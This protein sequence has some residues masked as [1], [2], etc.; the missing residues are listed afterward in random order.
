KDKEDKQSDGRVINLSFLLD[1]TNLG[2][3][4]ADFSILKKAITGRF[5]LCDD[6]IRQFISTMIPQLK[7]RMEKQGYQVHQ[8]TCETVEKV[9][10]AVNT[11]IEETL[12][13]EDDRVLNIVI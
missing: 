1:M 8:I 4:R 6:D 13:M 10:L 12:R 9:D 7:E 3:L 5:L 2:P 11:L